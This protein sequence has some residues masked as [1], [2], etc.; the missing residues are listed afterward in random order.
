MRH[1]HEKFAVCILKLTINGR[2]CHPVLQ[3][4]DEEVCIRKYRKGEDL[5]LPW[6]NLFSDHLGQ[7]T[8]L[9]MRNDNLIFFK[10][11]DP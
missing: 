9:I 6:R 10:T 5:I 11:T 2:T 8:L 7:I 4:D 3:Q 1:L